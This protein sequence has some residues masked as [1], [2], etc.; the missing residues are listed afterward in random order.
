M[1]NKETVRVLIG[2]ELKPLGVKYESSEGSFCR[3]LNREPVYYRTHFQITCDPS[4]DKLLIDYFAFTQDPEDP[5][6]YFAT[7][8]HRA[9]C[10]TYVQK[11]VF[12]RSWQYIS[13]ILI[14]GLAALS[15]PLLFAGGLYW[16]KIAIGFV[17]FEIV[18]IS[19][20]VATGLGGLRVL[21]KYVVMTPQNVLSL[22]VSA[23]ITSVLT[24]CIYKLLRLSYN[25]YW[26]LKT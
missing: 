18:I 20:Y 14:L 5:C 2:D 13:P 11:T 23:V 3:L 21:Q 7:A 12:Q 24:L 4:M 6:V 10:S 19:I 17:C 16:E 8:K 22:I 9:G 1:R 26:S 25:S 15:F